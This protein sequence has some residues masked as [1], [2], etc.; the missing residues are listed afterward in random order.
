[1]EAARQLLIERDQRGDERETIGSDSTADRRRRAR[2]NQLL[3]SAT[4]RGKRTTRTVAQ[5]CQS[6]NYSLV[7]YNRVVLT[8]KFSLT[9]QATIR[10]RQSQIIK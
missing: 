10:R 2:L 5:I 1:M 7:Q 9:W 3:T 8:L 6:I 4:R